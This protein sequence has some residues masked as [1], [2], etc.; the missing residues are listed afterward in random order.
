M[1]EELQKLWRG[2]K[3]ARRRDAVV[4]QLDADGRTIK[5]D[6]EQSLP[7]SGVSIQSA[8]KDASHD[9]GR[10][11]VEFTALREEYE[12]ISREA[13]IR[14]RE[15]SF[16]LARGRLAKLAVQWS[17]KPDNLSRCCFDSRLL[18]EG[19]EW[20]EWVQGVGKAVLEGGMTAPTKGSGPGSANATG[21]KVAASEPGENQGDEKPEG[22]PEEEE[23]GMDA[24]DSPWCDGRRKCERH[25]G[26]QKL[27]LAEFEL[28]K[29]TK[30]RAAL[31][32]PM[33][34]KL[35]ATPWIGNG[36]T[37][38]LTNRNGTQL[39]ARADASTSRY[40]SHP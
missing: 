40:H 39:P 7:N 5:T 1:K 23:F 31:A 4:L 17:E 30:V 37:K 11:N 21:E 36:D 15:L 10:L 22:A 24:A 26:W 18:M 27:G 9:F 38:A 35:T 12:S 8:R 19:N 2:V 6:V 29:G 28:N 32:L 34:N 14:T 13:Q 33:Y 25:F 3:D 20:E 16:I